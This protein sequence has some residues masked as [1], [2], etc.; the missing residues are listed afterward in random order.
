MDTGDAKEAQADGKLS[1]PL[2]P[3][4]SAAPPVDSKPATAQESSAPPP[5]PMQS[6]TAAERTP[7]SAAVL[8]EE[9]RTALVSSGLTAPQ[10]ATSHILTTAPAADT[11]GGAAKSEP[12]SMNTAAPPAT[13]ADQTTKAEGEEEGPALARPTEVEGALA[14]MQNRVRQVE[15]GVR[16]LGGDLRQAQANEQQSLRQLLTQ[17]E[18]TLRQG[19]QAAVREAVSA[20]KEE[21]RSL[22]PVAVPT[23][24]SSTEPPSPPLLPRPSTT[25]LSSSPLHTSA[26]VPAGERKRSSLLSQPSRP[27]SATAAGGAVEGGAD[28]LTATWQLPLARRT[29]SLGKNENVLPVFFSSPNSSAHASPKEASSKSAVFSGSRPK[30]PPVVTHK[31]S[32]P[33]PSPLSGYLE[34]VTEKSRPGVA[35]LKS[36]LLEMDSDGD[37]EG[38]QQRARS[39]SDDGSESAVRITTSS[40]SPP[41]E[42]SYVSDAAGPTKVL[43][44]K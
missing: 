44:L 41:L 32:P 3:Q 34:A 31:E 7:R 8:T 21:A 22:S 9:S 16:E 2:Q 40:S 17:M 18:Q 24:S 20:T 38:D 1:T 26:P 39:G 43:S 15:A 19:V 28:A 33:A 6:A 12:S 29:S 27:A 36:S 14:E 30:P 35:P 11:A 25:S 23:A 13:A 4:P 42:N 10:E 5:P 37:K